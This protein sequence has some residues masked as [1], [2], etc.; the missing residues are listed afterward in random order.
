[1]RYWQLFGLCGFT[2]LL[3]FAPLA[4]QAPEAKP[5][6]TV[7]KEGLLP[8]TF[9][10]HIVM[11]QRTDPTKPMQGK[12]NVTGKEHC[13]I[14][15]S[16]LNPTIAIFSGSL[17]KAESNI[18][19]LVKSVKVLHETY[20]ADDFNAFAIFHVLKDDFATDVNADKAAQTIQAWGD[21]IK[22]AGVVLG[23]GSKGTD[24]KPTEPM[25]A[26]ALAKTKDDAPPRERLQQLL[27]AL[28]AKEGM[29]LEYQSDYTVTAAEVFETGRGSLS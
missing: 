5:A 1:M 17:P 18:S 28:L 3:G 4:A 7:K 26:W 11:D 24:D 6:E 25:K 22:P 29:S 20:K 9:V 16:E 21:G 15:E 8:S 13:L 10:S 27:A 23:L 2:G 12:R 19:N 14:T